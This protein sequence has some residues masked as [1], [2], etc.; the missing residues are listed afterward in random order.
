[1]SSGTPS[2]THAMSPLCTSFDLRVEPRPPDAF[3]GTVVAAIAAALLDG[4]NGNGGVGSSKE[5]APEEGCDVVA[6]GTKEADKSG[7]GGGV[8]SKRVG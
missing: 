7:G 4:C 8:V 6:V 3:S 1:M 5:P 2:G